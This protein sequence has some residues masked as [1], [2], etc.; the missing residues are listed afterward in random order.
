MVETVWLG[1]T[2]DAD[3]EKHGRAYYDSAVIHER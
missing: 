2:K 1:T 3:A